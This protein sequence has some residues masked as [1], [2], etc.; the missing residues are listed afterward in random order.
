MTARVFWF[1][2]WDDRALAVAYQLE[3]EVA[4][5]GAPGGG[6][7]DGGGNNGGY[8][9]AL[10][11]QPRFHLGAV[12]WRSA[13][14]AAAHLRATHEATR[15]VAPVNR[16]SA[17]EGNRVGAAS[18][19]D[20]EASTAAEPPEGS[21]EPEIDAPPASS[22]SLLKACA[23]LVMEGDAGAA[24]TGGAPLAGGGGLT[25]QPGRRRRPLELVFVVDAAAAPGS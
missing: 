9:V 14:E 20:S 11:G 1:D 5:R 8:I 12:S 7:G 25:K 17:G 10:A 18:P 24:L 23:A 2:A 16:G 22:A 6:D 21:G 13:G 3:A 4:S 19:G 15:C